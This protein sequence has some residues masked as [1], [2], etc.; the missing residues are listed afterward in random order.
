M[1]ESVIVPPCSINAE[2]PTPSISPAMVAEPSI[3][4]T[5]VPASNETEFV[6]MTLLARSTC[7]VPPVPSMINDPGQ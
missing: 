7:W 1:P 2:P 5:Q 4:N 3:M 6:R